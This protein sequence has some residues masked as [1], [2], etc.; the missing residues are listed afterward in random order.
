MALPPLFAG[1][2]QVITVCPVPAV[3]VTVAGMPGI[4]NGVAATVPLAAPSPT[5]FTA[6]TRNVYAVAFVKPV[7]VYRTAWLPVD[8]VATVHD[9]PAFELY[10]TL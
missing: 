2:V 8:A 7:T 10:S 9:V 5:V 3:A 4:V 6:E 1:A